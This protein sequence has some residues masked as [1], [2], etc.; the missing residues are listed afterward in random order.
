MVIRRAATA[1]ARD[2]SDMAGK[3]CPPPPVKKT[4]VKKSMPKPKKPY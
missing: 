4:P 1:S 2:R 3:K